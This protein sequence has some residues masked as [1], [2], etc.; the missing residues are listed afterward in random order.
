MAPWILLGLLLTALGALFGPWAW[1]QLRRARLRRQPF[2]ADWREI[3]RRRMPYYAG[4]PTDLQLQLKGHVQVLVAEKPVIGCAGLVVTEEMRVL[5]AAQAALL[6]LNRPTAYF[7]NLREI[8]MYPG[9]FVV[10][11][12]EHDGAGLV[13]QGRRVL[14]GESWQRGQVILSW[15]DVLAGAAAPADGRNVVIH[16]FAHQ[17]DQQ[18][19]EANGA[20]FLGR[21]DRYAAWSA[22]LGAAFA[23][24]RQQLAHGGATVID[25]YGATAPAEFFAVVSELFFERPGALAQDHPALYQAFVGYYQVDPLSW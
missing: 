5:V 1:R 3:L 12:D 13:S 18:S 22:T 2:P 6:L 24:L 21:R 7:P 19:G 15:D 20:P 4:L 11:R 9:A 23:Q 17:L 25:P 8:L 16:E 10:Q 14:A